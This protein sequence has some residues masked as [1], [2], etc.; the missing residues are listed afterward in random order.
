MGE[1]DVSDKDSITLCILWEHEIR[2][3]ATLLR[4]ATELPEDAPQDIC[5]KALQDAFAAAIAALWHVT[6][7]AALLLS[8]A[9]KMRRRIVRGGTKRKP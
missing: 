5:D 2:L 1:S 4:A 8:S 7:D 6:D 3:A 9:D